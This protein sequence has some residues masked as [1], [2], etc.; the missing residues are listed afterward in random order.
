MSE[1]QLN[2]AKNIIEQIKGGRVAYEDLPITTQVDI[3]QKLLASPTPPEAILLQASEGR[4]HEVTLI[5][6]DKE[7]PMDKNVYKVKPGQFVVAT[8]E[9]S[10]AGWSRAQAGF[11]SE[12]IE[13]SLS[14]PTITIARL[15]DVL[16]GVDLKGKSRKQV[17]ALLLEHILSGG[18]V[19]D[20]GID[21]KHRLIEEMQGQA[22]SQVTVVGEVKEPPS[23]ANDGGL[24]L[25]GKPKEGVKDLD[26]DMSNVRS[27]H[28]IG[29]NVPKL[30]QINPQNN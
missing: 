10:S 22:Y 9:R 23:A 11:A 27:L 24:I 30:K 25:L 12:V 13:D 18:G 29:V 5:G 20:I 21:E 14:D 15:P 8:Y 28:I 26:I 7:C 19:E 4:Q 2:Q 17:R 1:S 6:G 16:E 3:Y